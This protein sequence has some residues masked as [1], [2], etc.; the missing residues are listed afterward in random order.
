MHEHLISNLTTHVSLM[1]DDKFSRLC[2]EVDEAKGMIRKLKR[3]NQHLQTELRLHVNKN[4]E[5]LRRLQE[6]GFKTQNLYTE[7]RRQNDELMRKY[8]NLEKEHKDLKLENKEL[9]ER[10]I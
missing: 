6:D 10:A 1:V 4:K 2:R 5:D 8:E 9:H 3:E 7:I